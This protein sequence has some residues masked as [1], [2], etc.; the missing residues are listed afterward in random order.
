MNTSLLQKTISKAFP[1]KTAADA[2]EV[3]FLIGL[4]MLAVALHA[5]L[6]LPM[7]LPGKQGVL[8]MA[9]ILTG[10]G[11]SKFPYAG[12]LSGIGAA[13]MLLVPGLGFHD[14][15]MA[16]Q[17]LFLGCI[18]DVVAGLITRNTERMWLVAIACGACWMLIPFFRLT[19]S[20]FVDIPMGS[21]RNGYL[22]PFVTHLLFGMTG[23][24]IAAGLLALSNRKS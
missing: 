6:R 8:F 21:F 1:N 20:V 4:G 22:F 15:F 18:I 7:Q 12:S 5:K 24:A 14:P 9:L 10:K 13:T 11:M 17:Y 2:V 16:I 3:L 19:L 23:G